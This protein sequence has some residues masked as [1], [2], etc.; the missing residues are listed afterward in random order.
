MDNCFSINFKTPAFDNTGIFHILEHLS[1]SGSKKYPI[2]DVFKNMSNRSFY[3]DINAFTGCDNTMFIFSTENKKD[4]KNLFDIFI[5]SA[6]NP[7]LDYLDFLQE[8]WRYEFIEDNSENKKGNE[9]IIKGFIFNEMKG[10]MGR[11][12]NF[13]L[14]KIRSNLFVKSTYNY[15]SGGD[16]KEI[17]KLKYEDLIKAHKK[18]YHPSNTKFISYGDL[19]FTENLKNLNENLLEKYEKNTDDILIEDS[20]RIEK[21]REII[22]YYIPELLGDSEGTSKF[23]IS[24]LCQNINENLYETFKM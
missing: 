16:P 4:F 12:E 10:Q 21:E 7:N 6:F 1:H 3:S 8:G 14:Q 19:D 24:F 15:N 17:H 2:R 22:D 9:L 23:S 18:Y 11:Q 5:D 13:F 20:I